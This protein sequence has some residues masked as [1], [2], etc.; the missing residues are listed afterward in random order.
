MRK[1][2]REENRQK[3]MEERKC[4]VC[5]GFG[6]IAYYYRNMEKEGSVQVPSNKFKVLRD[7][8]MQREEGS[9]REVVKDRK[10][11]L[12][13]ERAKRGIERYKKQKW[14]RRKKEEKRKRNY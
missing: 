7:K 1:R 2:R 10:E 9:G 11:I 12:K 8:V 13:E 14:K 3:A 5:G 6:H 4:F